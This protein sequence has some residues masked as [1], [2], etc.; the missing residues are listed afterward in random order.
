MKKFLSKAF[1]SAAVLTVAAAQ[2]SVF[3]VSAAETEYEGGKYAKI[4]ISTE[5]GNGNE[6]EKADGYQK[7]TIAVVSPVDEKGEFSVNEKTGKVIY[8]AIIPA[9]LANL[10]D[11]LIAVIVVLVL[12]ASM[13]T[14]SSLVLTSSS[15]M[16]LDLIKGK[17]EM[18]EKKQVLIM[19]VL[20]VFFVAVSSIIAILQYKF[21]FAFIAQLMGLSWG[22]LAGAFLAPFLYGLYWKRT[23]VASAWVS[24]GFGTIVMLVNTF[25]PSIVPAWLQSPINC[26]AFVM[27]AGLVIVPVVSLMTPVKNKNEVEEAFSSMKNAE[28]D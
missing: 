20:V 19:R 14:L 1:V 6:I 15:T 9:M 17:K 11:L 18:K 16:T 13:S 28:K 22:A 21:G 5:S 24:F 8:D 10:P 2:F 12:S 23:T 7:S 25:V 4:Y 26:G 3:S 27:L